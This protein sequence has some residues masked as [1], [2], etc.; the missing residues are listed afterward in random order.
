MAPPMQFQTE[1]GRA[2]KTARIIKTPLPK[3]YSYLRSRCSDDR[4]F[5]RYLMEADPEIDTE[6]AG[7]YTGPTDRALLDARGQLLYAAT[8]VE[9]VR[10][11]SGRE[12]ERRPPVE[13]PANVDTTDTPGLDGQDVQAP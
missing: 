1:A 5:A 9:V 4:E 3:T 2:V 12:A 11:Q 8:E 10:D 6:A 7:R 13:M